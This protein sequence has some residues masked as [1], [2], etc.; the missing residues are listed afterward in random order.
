MAPSAAPAIIVGMDPG[1][2]GR[3]T[4]VDVFDDLK[5]LGRRL[6][7]LGALDTGWLDGEGVAPGDVVLARARRV[8]T[9]LLDLDVPRPRVYPTPEGGVQAEWTIDDHE[10]S[11]AF[12]PDGTLYAISVDVVSGQSIEPELRQ[13]N[14]EQIAELLQV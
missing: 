6:D 9:E 13:D 3:L 5:A 14:P 10:I 2:T 1:D 7:E 11:V 12:E 8:L 4:S